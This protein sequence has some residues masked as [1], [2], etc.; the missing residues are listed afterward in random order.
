[1]Y[2]IVPWYEVVIPMPNNYNQLLF[3]QQWTTVFCS[4]TKGR[5]MTIGRFFAGIGVL[6]WNPETNKYLILKRSEEKDFAAGL[7]ECIT[8]RVDQGEGF[9]DAAHREVREEIDSPVELLD[10]MGTTHF[11]RG[12]RRPEFELIGVVYLG[13]IPKDQEIQIGIEHSEYRWATSAEVKSLLTPYEGSEEWLERVISRA[14]SRIS[15]LPP[16]FFEMNQQSGF[17]LDP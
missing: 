16:H 4:D 9:E 12:E 10:I 5:E 15:S 11:Y 1:M 7:W 8:G 14:E 17:E 3:D 6:I 13:C 2:L